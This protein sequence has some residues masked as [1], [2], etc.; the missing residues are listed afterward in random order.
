[1]TLCTQ[2]LR[3]TYAVNLQ[4]GRMVNRKTGR[5][6]GAV[7]QRGR[8]RFYVGN[9]QYA[10]KRVVWQLLTGEE[11]NGKVVSADG[12]ATNIAWDNLFLQKD[13]GCVIR[14][15]DAIISPDAVVFGRTQETEACRH[16][17]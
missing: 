7:D 8:V 2:N 15:C 13:D 3:E 5:V 1:M 6:I 12:V 17:E 4:S 14:A 16:G 10:M 9:K 11:P